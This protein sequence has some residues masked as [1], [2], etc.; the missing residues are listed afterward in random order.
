MRS[1]VLT[2]V[3][4]KVLPRVRVSIGIVLD[5]ISQRLLTVA[6]S[7]L[8]WSSMNGGSLPLI[9]SSKSKLCYDRRSVCQSVLVSSIHLVLKTGFLLL[10]DSCGFVDVGRYLWR[11]DGSVVYNCCWFSPV[12]SFLGPSPAGLVTIF[13]FL[14]FKTPPTWRAR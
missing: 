9:Y 11:E 12:Q 2:L 6:I 13:Y 4:S 14:R 1:E 5:W 10:S 7:L 8:P 3:S